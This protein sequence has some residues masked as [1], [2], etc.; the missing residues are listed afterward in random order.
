VGTGEFDF[1]YL[2]M[3]KFLNLERKSCGFKNIRI[4]V[5]GVR[6]MK[7]LVTW[8][9]CKSGAYDATLLI[10]VTLSPLHDAGIQHVTVKACLCKSNVFAKARKTV[11]TSFPSV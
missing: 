11:A 1:E 7:Y 8:T 6:G 9:V 3:G 4:H 2:W 10:E 5:N